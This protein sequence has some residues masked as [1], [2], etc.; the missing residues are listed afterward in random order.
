MKRK[1]AVSLFAAF[2]FSLTSVFAWAD[3]PTQF[4]RHA[5]F[6]TLVTLPRAIEGLTGDGVRNL[7]TGGSGTAACPI[8]QINLHNQSVKVVGNVPA[9]ATPSGTCGFSGITFDASGNLYAADGGAGRIY[10]F[11]PNADSPPD[12]TVFAL[13][14]PGTNGLAF[15][16]DGNLWTGDGTTGLG[17]VWKIAPQGGIC[18]AAVN[19]YHGCEEVF[20]IQPMSNDLDPTKTGGIS[21]VGSDRRTLPPGTIGTLGTAVRTATNTGASQPLVAN[22]LAFN[23]DA[24]TLFIADTARG[25]IWKAT[26]NRGGHLKSKTGCDRTFTRNTLCLDNIFVAHPFLEAADGIALDRDENIWVD[27]NERQAVVGIT[28]DAK[29][30]QV[31]RNPVN[32]TGLRNSADTA[33]GNNHI[34]EF[35]TSPFLTGKVFCTAQSDGN[36]RDNFPNTAGQ[37]SPTGPNIGKISCMNQELTVR[38][39][40]L[41]VR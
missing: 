3:P 17:R 7:Y 29:V 38:G 25:A 37:V 5:T 16:H 27:A 20:R 24:D 41:P 33:R 32:S 10:T 4:P 26:F 19:P 6:T 2:V 35:P 1:Y 34:L 28:K 39:L 18:E 21:N 30:I 40:P 8:W 22:G 31:F 9:A 36:R 13:G 23:K 12:A 11:K 14:V 15:D